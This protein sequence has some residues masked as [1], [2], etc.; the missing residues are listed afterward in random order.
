M[1]V[2]ALQR[3]APGRWRGRMVELPA[4]PG[5]PRREAVRQLLEGQVRAFE[6]FVADAPTQWWTLLFPIWEDSGERR[7]P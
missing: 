3:T 1:Y 4:P 6:S 7:I 5:V 2:L